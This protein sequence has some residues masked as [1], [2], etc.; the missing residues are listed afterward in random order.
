MFRLRPSWDQVP[1]DSIWLFP[2]PAMFQFQ[3][4][5]ADGFDLMETQMVPFDATCP[6]ASPTASIFSGSFKSSQETS[7]DISDYHQF[8][9]CQV[10]AAPSTAAP[11]T[12]KASSNRKTPIC[13]SA[14]TGK[15][16][17]KKSARLGVRM[18][19]SKRK[20][21]RDVKTSKKGKRSKAFGMTKKTAAKVASVRMPKKRKNEKKDTE[22]DV[23][24]EDI[25]MTETPL[26]QLFQWPEHMTRMF[27][28]DCCDSQKKPVH[29]QLWTEFSGAGTPEFALNALAS[30][31][32]EHLSVKVMGQCDWNN[33]AQTCL[34][35]NSDQET[36]LFG[37]IAGVM[38]EEMKARAERRVAVE[39][40]LLC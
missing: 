38:S 23:R 27:F 25:T 22:D 29:V 24:P 5:P 7:M 21:K 9:I 35:N 37:D 2:L 40:A 15:S 39:A 20:Q 10:P 16:E 26:K 17:K 6:K 3:N 28:N 34:I 4:S 36:H 13:S 33:A 30:Q 32:P 14:A 12:Q 19:L 1:G 11:S 31:V 18:T 8:A